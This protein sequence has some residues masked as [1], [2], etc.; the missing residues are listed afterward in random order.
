MNP[1]DKISLGKIVV[2]REKLLKAQREGKKIYRFESGDPSFDV[3][4][5]VKVAMEKALKENKLK[6]DPKNIIH[7]D[8]NQDYA[9]FATKELLKSKNR[10]DA[11][12]TISDRMAIGA[13]I[14]IKE[15]GLKMPT[16]IGLMGFNNEPM[17]SLLT[18][19]IS[20]IEQ[21]MFEMGKLAAKIFIERLHSEDSTVTTEVLK[22]RL[23]IR[24]SSKRKQL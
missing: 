21:T 2:I 9:Y 10:P 23:I 8:F 15:R 18:P 19:T 1:L 24:E 11:I 16:D 12:F 22:P 4:P 20:S 13:M 7:C 3:H 17:L 5:N 6:I 14:A